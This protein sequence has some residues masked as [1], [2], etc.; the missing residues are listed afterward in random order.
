[1]RSRWRAVDG[2]TFA[3]YD[4]GASFRLLTRFREV[5]PLPLGERINVIYP[6]ATPSLARP[7]AHGAARRA[8]L[9]LALA[10][11]A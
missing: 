9:Y 1:M 6:L 11:A 7:C 10:T 8:H 2:S 4:G 5:A 3:P